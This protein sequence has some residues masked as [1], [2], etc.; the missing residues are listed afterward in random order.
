MRKVKLY[1]NHRLSLCY[2]SGVL[3]A[4]CDDFESS[5]DVFEA[6]GGVLSEV[7][8]K[9]DSDLRKL[10]DQLMHLLKP[11][12]QNGSVNKQEHKV[13]DAPVTLGSISTEN[14]LEETQSLW[15]SKVEDS[16]VSHFKNRN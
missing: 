5:E 13:L 12:F 16:L 4:S 15:I 3:E 8:D 14:E 9:S 6:I 10:C 2:F 1:K 7:S 11:N